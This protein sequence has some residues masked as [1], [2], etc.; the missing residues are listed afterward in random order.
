MDSVRIC[1]L[2]IVT[3]HLNIHPTSAWVVLRV[4]RSAQGKKRTESEGSS[5]ICEPA[6]EKVGSI[7]PLDPVA[8]GPLTVISTKK[9]ISFSYASMK[10]LLPKRIIFTIPVVVISDNPDFLCFWLYLALL[11]LQKYD[12]LNY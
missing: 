8:P 6:P 1:S 5:T 12:T 4:D 9:L 11:C 2:A 7:D 3:Q 10:H